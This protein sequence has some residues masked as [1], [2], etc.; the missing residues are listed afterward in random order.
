MSIQAQP[1]TFFKTKALA[2]AVAGSCTQTSK[3]PCQSYSLPTEACKTGSKMAQIE[4]SICSHCYANKGNYLRYA[5]GI[6]PAQIKRLESITSADWVGAMV[7]Q[8]GFA[9]E[10]FRWHDSG[11]I[12]S[13]D[14]LIKI[15]QIAIAMPST[16]FWL[17][18]REYAIVKD[19]VDL[20]EIPSNLT[21][22]LSAMFIDQP[23]IIPVS[24]QGL[25]GASNVHAKGEVS[26][27]ACN[28]PSTNG[29]CRDCRKCWDKSLTISYM[30]H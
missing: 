11:D 2:L 25:V 24:L 3:M 21:V 16:Q 26:G 8:I 23:V 22:R 27:E 9:S 17:P 4:G 15:A 12:Q 29:E 10:Y 5:N 1:I 20:Y 30:A 28:A 6:K 13:L 19:F 14:H 18:T 7:K